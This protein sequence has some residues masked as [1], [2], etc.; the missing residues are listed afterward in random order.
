MN[1][2]LVFV[3]LAAAVVA[4]LLA[5]MALVVLLRFRAELGRQAAATAAMQQ[6]LRALCNA[7]VAVGERVNRLE[8]TARDVAA[9]QEEIGVRQDRLDQSKGDER[10][11]EQAIKLAQKGAPV[12]DLVELCGLARGE[13]ELIAMLH[14]LDAR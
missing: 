12:E 5:G 7:A 1:E 2:T 11:Y 13:A 14:R 10:S 4:A 8:T 3:A 6:D 9:R